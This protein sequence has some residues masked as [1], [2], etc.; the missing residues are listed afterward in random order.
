[1]AY[2]AWLR[3]GKRFA[4]YYFEVLSGSQSQNFHPTDYVD[5][6]PVEDRKRA[7]LFAHASQH[8]EGMY[9]HH[10]AMSRFRGY[11]CGKTHAEAYIRHAQSRIIALP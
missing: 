7:A 1:M 11:E 10:A 3:S 2:D 5:I 8:P 6:S 9:A 4:L